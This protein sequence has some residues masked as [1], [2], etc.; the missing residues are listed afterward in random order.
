M[1]I[2]QE[3]TIPAYSKSV[4]VRLNM[5]PGH[6]LNSKL[7]FFQPSRTRLKLGLTLEATP[8]MEVS[9]RAVYVLINN[10]TAKD[11]NIPKVSHLG[12]LINQAFH[13][14]ELT[15]PVISPIPAELM[16]DECEDTV[17]FTKPHEVI[18]IT[19][20]LPVSKESVCRSELTDDTHL[21]VY[22]VSTQPATESPAHVTIKA[23]NPSNDSTEEPYAGSNAQVQ[24]ILSEADALHSEMD[25]Q[26]LK[27]VLCKYKDSFAKD[28]LDCGLTDIHTVRI[29]T[30]PNAPPTFVRQ[31]KIPI[32]SYE[33]VQEFIYSMLEKGV[34]RP[35]NSTYSAP[36]WPVLKPNGKWRPTIDYRKLNQQVPLSRWPMTQLDQEIPKIKGSMILSTLDV[37][38]GFWTIPVH[39]DDQHKLAFTFGNRQYTFT[40]CPFG[41]ANSPAEFNIFP[42]K[43]C[44]DARARG[45]LFSVD[46]LMKSSNVADQLKEIDHV[47]NQLTTAGAKIALH[48]GQWCKTKVN[49]VGLLIGHGGIE[50]QSSCRQAIQNIKTP[51]NISE[52]Q[53]FLGVCNYSRQFIE[54][55][56]DIARP[57]TYLLKKDEPFVWSEAQ[58]TAMSKLKECLC[59]APCLAYPDPEKEFYLE[60]GFSNHCLSAGL[61]QLHDRDK[62]VVAY[63]SKTLLPPEC[64]YSDCEKALLCT[65]WAIQ[66]FSNYIGAQKVIIEMCHQPVTFLNSQLAACQNCSTDMLYTSA[67]PKELA[68]LQLTNYRYFDENVCEGMPTAYVDGCSY[69]QQGNLKAGPGVVCL[70]D[71][72][73]PPQKFK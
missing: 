48:K 68:Q 36:I 12:W 24:Q 61:Y 9:S 43:A 32:A 7:G 34:I 35:C 70:N 44:P 51:T 33:L 30:H 37:A 18:A 57:L 15:V 17:T 46:V 1:S 52:L 20:I 40:R 38:S 55:Y 63:A 39:P 2:E 14:F 71:N 22:A 62:R 13:D 73:R 49:Y 21:A 65:V 66:R 29:P 5:R 67:E 27:E 47:L 4:S 16:S 64:K 54:N 31:Y 60:A 10:C 59:S 8:L 25:R 6:T 69:N 19:S 58:D 53:S 72:P 11:S 42:N 23:Q 50:P 56:A 26:G 28:S 41:Y 3:A 45:N